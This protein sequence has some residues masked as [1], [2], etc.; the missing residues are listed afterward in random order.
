MSK[1]NLT[2]KQRLRVKK[3]DFEACLAAIRGQEIPV[4]LG[5]PLHRIAITRGLRHHAGY[6]RELRGVLPEFTRALNAQDIMNNS[7]PDIQSAEDTP[8]CIWHP[9]TASETTYR[10]LARRYPSM[11]YHVGRACAVAGYTE[12]YQELDILPDVH[13]A[14]EARECGSLEIFH[15]IMSQPI[16]YGIMDDYN[17]SVDTSNRQQAYL[18]GDTAVRWTLEFK[19]EIPK[20]HNRSGSLCSHDA[21]VSRWARRATFNI[22]EDMNVAEKET[23]LY[24][25]EEPFREKQL[26]TR[27]FAQFLTEPLPADLPFIEKDLLIVMAA[28]HGDIDRYVRLRRPK[29]VIG[30]LECCAHGIHHNSLFAAWWAKQHSKS[31]YINKAIDARFIMEDILSR[32]P[33]KPIPYMI[34]WP[35]LAHESTYRALSRLQPDDDLSPIVHACIYGGYV[36]LF[37]ELLPKITPYRALLWEAET[38]S[39]HHFRDALLARLDALGMTQETMP[40]TPEKYEYGIATECIRQKLD[41]AYSNNVLS[42]MD[43]RCVRTG[44]YAP[45]NGVSCDAEDIIVTACAPDEWKIFTE[46]EGEEWAS[47]ETYSRELDYNKWPRGFG[48]SST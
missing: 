8:Y 18:N 30:E 46:E 13:I 7:I 22:T 16:R 20:D 31:S 36:E 15:A 12:L 19:T 29:M 37:D 43:H 1:Q 28:Y 26:S 41:R 34:W 47:Y 32:A 45:Y 33:Y 10:E 38:Q 25:C 3:F 5:H 44:W 14:E 6:G 23:P 35:K 48:F 11:A 4:G 40:F 17:L 9:T 39:N 21:M 24:G 27:P 42:A 2:L